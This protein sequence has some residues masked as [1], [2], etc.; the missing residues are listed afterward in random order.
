MWVQLEGVNIL[1]DVAVV[2]GRA[3]EGLRASLG[4]FFSKS[5]DGVDRTVN[6]VSVGPLGP[7]TGGCVH[8]GLVVVANRRVDVLRGLP[9]PNTESLSAWVAIVESTIFVVLS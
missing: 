7:D 1:R 8:E 2:E 5:A 6:G 4:C 9:G 3:E